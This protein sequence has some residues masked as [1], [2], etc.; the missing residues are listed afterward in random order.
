MHLKRNIA[1]TLFIFISAS[2]L[3]QPYQRTKGQNQKTI[4]NAAFLCV[5]GK[6]IT[7]VGGGLSYEP[8]FYLVEKLYSKEQALR[9]AGGL[10]WDWD[11]SK[12]PHLVAGK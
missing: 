6:F 10:V 3:A 7:S 4:R 2:L 8:A 11:L 9:T 1:F 5:D 12:V